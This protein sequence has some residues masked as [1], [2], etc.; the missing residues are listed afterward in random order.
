MYKLTKEKYLHDDEQVELKRILERFEAKFPRD[1]ALIWLGLHSGAR[2]TELLNIKFADLDELR[3]TVY[4]R[5]IKKSDDRDMPLPDWLFKKLLVLEPGS[6]GRIFPISYQRLH[7]IWGDYRPVKKK[8][9]S[10]RHTF[11]INLYRKSKD[12]KL[13]QMALGH[14]NWNNTMIYAD[15]QYKTDELKRV[16]LG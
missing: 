10:L 13:L 16:L 2:A 8:F 4:I 15:Y 5:G 7:Q 9:H 11:A 14:R 6:D 1:T 12:I 3:R